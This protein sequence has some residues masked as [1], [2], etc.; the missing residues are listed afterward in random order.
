MTDHLDR[1][2]ARFGPCVSLAAQ[3][4][5][6]GPFCIERIALAMLVSQLAVGAAHF[7]DGVGGGL[8]KTREA[9]AIGATRLDPI[10]PDRAQGGGPGLRL[11]IASSACQK[12]GPRP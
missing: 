4:R 2:G 12:R 5:A 7:D 11:L 6:G 8:E 10:G 1:M 3:H 9:R